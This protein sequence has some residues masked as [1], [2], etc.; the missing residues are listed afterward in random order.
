MAA[1]PHYPI[2]LSQ[3]GFGTSYRNYAGNEPDIITKL[4]GLIQTD[5]PQELYSRGEIA[6]M[7]ELRNEFRINNAARY[8]AYRFSVGMNTFIGVGVEQQVGE[9]ALLANRTT[10]PIA[11][12]IPS[13]AYT[14]WTVINP[15]GQRLYPAIK[16]PF[17]G[18][19]FSNGHRTLTFPILLE[20]F[21]LFVYFHTSFIHNDMK[22]NNFLYNPATQKVCIIDFGNT[23]PFRLSVAGQINMPCFHGVGRYYFSYPPESLFSS[24]TLGQPIPQ[25]LIT[26]YYAYFATAANDPSIERGWISSPSINTMLE[27]VF[28]DYFRTNNAGIYTLTDK[29]SLWIGI[30]TDLYGF[31]VGLVDSLQN[32]NPVYNLEYNISNRKVRFLH[33]VGRIQLLLT[34]IHPRLRPLHYSILYYFKSFNISLNNPARSAELKINANP[35]FKL[36]VFGNEEVY[37]NPNSVMALGMN[38]CPIPLIDVQEN[39]LIFAFLIIKT[40]AEILAYFRSTERGIFSKLIYRNVYADA[41]VYFNNSDNVEL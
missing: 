18:E 28:R 15:R 17:L 24:I 41:I 35:Y 3:G 31:G 27:I 12:H 40:R 21:D 1:R 2:F 20:C 32:I 16:M 13:N 19:N 26:Q 6:K 7:N 30:T 4:Y 5:Y 37:T 22:L 9:S 39:L 25:Y 23:K 34:H 29:H 33:I 14:F 10:F 38:N 8:P 11:A 36:S